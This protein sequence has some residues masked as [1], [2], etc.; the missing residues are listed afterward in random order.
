MLGKGDSMDNV[1]FN[2]AGLVAYPS[3]PYDLG[4]TIKHS[5]EIIHEKRI[6][7]LVVWEENDIPGKFIGTEVM[8]EIDKGNIFIADVTV[9]NFN[10]VFE[11]GYAIGRKKRAFLIRNETIR[12]AGDVIRE[13]GIFDTL[14]Y[15]PYNDSTSLSA[16]LSEVT[17]LT[18]IKFDDQAT[19]NTTPVYVLLP[20][21]KGDIETHII[22]RIK[23]ARLFYRSFDPAEVGRLSAVEAIEN[24]AASHGIVVPLLQH[25]HVDS[26]VHNLRAA[27]IAGLSIGMN[28]PLL[29][30]Q[31]GETP[32]PIDYRDFVKSFKY[33]EQIDE[34]V[35]NFA[36]EVT[37]S[38]Q[39]IRH[40]IIE[41]PTSFLSSL[42]LGASSAENEYREL[43]DYYLETDEYH[44]ARRGEVN[45]VLGRKGSGKTAL[46]FQ[47]RDSIRQ[48]KQIVVLDLKPE[49]FQ[50]LKF[51]EQVLD[52]LE[53]GT[54]EHTITA[55]WEYL[56]LLEICH[57]LL[58]ND[59]IIHLR[60]HE[61]Y[62]SYQQMAKA[63]DSDQYIGEGDFSERMLILIQRI[64]EDFE[65][66]RSLEKKD[67]RLDSKKI[68][69]LIYKHDVSTLIDHLVNYLHHKKAI[70][71]LF[72]NLDKGWPPYGIKPEDVLSL[73]CLLDAIAKIERAFSR[74]RIEAKGIIFVRNDVYENLVKVLPDR[75][76]VS[77]VLV[78]WTDP[79]LL[80]ELLRRRFLYSGVDGDHSFMDLW[81]QICVSHIHGEDSAYYMIDRCLMRPRS[82]IEFLRFCR[83]H[84]VNLGHSRIEIE[85]IEQG[86]E[87]Y[88]TQL[89][90]D[91]SYEIR[92]IL[93]E[94]A[95]VLYSFIECPAE[96]EEN[97]ISKIINNISPDKAVQICI[98][99]LLLWYGVLGFKR[100]D[101]EAAFI[102]S[103]R[104]DM[105]RLR[106]HLNN[107]E[108]EKD[109]IRYIIN[110][111]FWKGLEIKGT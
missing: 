26:E 62:E 13:V 103:V 85:D 86:E 2:L 70:W 41:T 63:Y 58:Q 90:N 6:C 49:G 59:K 104:Y 16:M 94:A 21:T 75:G 91:I 47:L 19:N 33:P 32:V 76:K 84:A 40:L 95:D 80:L 108:N 53:E 10:V 51:K 93:P 110:P 73:R 96:I 79:E 38:I 3:E 18:P 72:D 100:S 60:D 45:V 105:R 39:S 29:L 88:S 65:Q 22:A 9:M 55:F 111:A 20:K 43:G 17:N 56:L 54:R 24:V 50:L 106:A 27:F 30:L 5:I 81:H 25:Y 89:V 67:Q 87:R 64:V 46:F 78:D 107:R 83:S 8:N 71:I 1:T 34:Y 74:Q 52:Y 92:D 102:Y 12:P 61:I 99:E 42:K 35:G 98:M 77:T 68:T 66:N 23:K 57:K 14:G 82:L 101:G 44:S 48:D 69:E 15:L 37:A 11:I 31:S 7:R 4:S 28:K 109:K 36:T 97:D